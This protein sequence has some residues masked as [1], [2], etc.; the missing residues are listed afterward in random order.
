M[1]VYV[2]ESIHTRKHAL[3]CTHFLPP[4]LLPSLLSLVCCK[5]QKLVCLSSVFA[6]EAGVESLKYVYI[7][8]TTR[9]RVSGA[10][11]AV[12][13]CGLRCTRWQ[14]QL[15]EYQDK[16]ASA[17]PVAS[18]RSVSE[19]HQQVCVRETY[20]NY[21]DVECIREHLLPE[22]ARVTGHVSPA[23]AALLGSLLFCIGDCARRVRNFF[24]RIQDAALGAEPEV[25]GA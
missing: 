13:A 14:E 21:L 2:C 10:G 24:A 19:E 11:L 1:R 17:R 6:G 20:E 5:L 3:I 8:P 7:Y 18:G 9:A 15:K 23:G 4:T 12:L 16:K 22:V 25:A